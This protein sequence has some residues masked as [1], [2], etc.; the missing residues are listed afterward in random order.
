MDGVSHV[1]TQHFPKE[2][3]KNAT[4]WRSDENTISQAGGAGR[5]VFQMK[6]LKQEIEAT[7]TSSL[8]P[9]RSVNI[10]IYQN[11]LDIYIFKYV[12][13]HLFILTV[14][15]H[16]HTSAHQMGYMYNDVLGKRKYIP[17]GLSGDT[18][19]DG[20]SVDSKVPP[21]Y[22]IEWRPAAEG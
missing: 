5:T 21:I 4:V 17:Y 19:R 10:N 20:L 22:L 12:Y 3:K 6:F 2:R 9:D 13:G 18:R 1:S 7:K 16:A 11:T 15:I 14:A 8:G